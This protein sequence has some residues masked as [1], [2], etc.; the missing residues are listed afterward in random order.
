M[1]GPMITMNR[2]ISVTPKKLLNKFG[3]I[4]INYMLTFRA[5]LGT[6]LVAILIFDILRF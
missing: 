4:E 5:L 2:P 6:S 1:N 3:E